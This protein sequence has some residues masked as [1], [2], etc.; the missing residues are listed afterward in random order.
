[1]SSARD[2]KGNLPH[3]PP[4]TASLDSWELK[5]VI[6]DPAIMARARATFELH[7]WAVR[8]ER[9]NLRRRY[10]QASPE[11]I[12]RRLRTWLHHRPGAEHGDAAG[13]DFKP[14]KRFAH[15]LGRAETD[16]S[17]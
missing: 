13:P 12:A 7:D 3:P 4:A 5:P 6:R 2:P 8:T 10:P 14:S 16:R 17:R 11:E 9:Q 15:L 1:M